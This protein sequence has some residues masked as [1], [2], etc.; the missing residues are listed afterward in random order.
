MI[1]ADLRVI[2]ESEHGGDQTANDTCTE[3][4]ESSAHQMKILIWPDPTRHIKQHTDGKQRD[5]QM[6]ECGVNRAAQRLSFQ[7]VFNGGHG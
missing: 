4:K 3:R 7:H 2:D 6:N 5:R 1:D